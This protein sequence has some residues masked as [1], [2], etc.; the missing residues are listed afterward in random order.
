MIRFVQDDKTLSLLI[1]NKVSS[2]TGSHADLNQSL[3]RGDTL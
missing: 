2:T 3:S 1:K